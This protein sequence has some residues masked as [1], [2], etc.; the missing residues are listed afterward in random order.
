MLSAFPEGTLRYLVGK[1]SRTHLI[2]SKKP[3]PGCEHF[4]QELLLR[5]SIRLLPQALAMAANGLFVS[6][7]PDVRKLF[8]AIR[9]AEQFQVRTDPAMVMKYRHA[10]M[11]YITNVVNDASTPVEEID[12]AGNDLLKL[13]EN[14]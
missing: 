6:K 11:N 4:W 10:A 2:V 13:L 8:A 1:E 7:Y 3:N 5:S 14:N 9:A 12:E